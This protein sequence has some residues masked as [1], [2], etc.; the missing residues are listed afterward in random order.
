MTHNKGVIW[1]SKRVLEKYV[2]FVKCSEEIL[3][4]RGIRCL[5]SALCYWWMIFPIWITSMWQNTFTCILYEYCVSINLIS[6]LLPFYKYIH[7]YLLISLHMNSHILF[8]TS[9]VCSSVYLFVCLSVYLYVFMPIWP[10]RIVNDKI[11]GKI[12]FAEF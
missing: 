12:F 4:K 8:Y 9:C 10:C 11:G 3:A 7:T 5:W 1:Y 2:A 6:M